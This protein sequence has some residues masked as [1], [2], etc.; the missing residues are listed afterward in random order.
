ML[1][2]DILIGVILIIAIWKGWKNGFV[3]QIVA[4]ASVFIGI[5]VAGKFWW[6]LNDFLKEKFNW[7]ETILKYISMIL[8]AILIILAVIF[9]GKLF[10]KLIEVT[11]FGVFDKILGLILS[12]IQAVVVL[13]F[14]VY[15]V[16][17]FF[18]EN[19]FFTKEKMDKSYTLPFIEPIAKEIVNYFDKEID[20]DNE[21]DLEQSKNNIVINL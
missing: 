2:A 12:F 8:T 3:Y 17:Y 10:S 7:N 5:F 16:N 21:K 15:G 18:P 11:I 4:L 19:N 20:V 9:I 6:F 1:I 14:I 13:S